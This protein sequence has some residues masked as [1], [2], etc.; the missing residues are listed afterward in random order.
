MKVRSGSFDVKSKRV[1]DSDRDA[2]R[3][4]PPESGPPAVRVLARSHPIDL[5]ARRWV[6]A[7][8]RDRDG[9]G[10]G[11][12]IAELR[13]LDPAESLRTSRAEAGDQ[14]RHVRVPRA[15][16]VEDADGRRS[17][18]DDMGDSRQN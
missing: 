1:S 14:G 18:L 16:T 3:R 5:P 6:R 11:G 13:Q 4:A 15:D 2:Q 12:K 10:R 17:S 8:T 7:S 9:R